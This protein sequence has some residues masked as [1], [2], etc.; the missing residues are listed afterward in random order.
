M[1][2]QQDALREKADDFNNAGNDAYRKKDFATAIFLYTEGIKV[3]CKDKELVSKLYNNRSTIYFYRGNYH[4]CLSDVKAATTLQPSYLKAIIRGK[5]DYVNIDPD[6]QDLLEIKSRS[7]RESETLP[8]LEGDKAE[9]AQGDP[10][11]QP[12]PLDCTCK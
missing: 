10:R 1:D 4:D 11:T 3:E 9:K 6:K 7:Y 5:N 8:T 2:F 12:K